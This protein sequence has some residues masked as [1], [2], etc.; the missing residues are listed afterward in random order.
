MNADKDAIPRAIRNRGAVR[1]RNITVP[2]PRHQSGKTL[3]LKQSIDS[4]RDIE[5]QIFLENRAA[6]RSGILAAVAGI[7]N[8]QSKWRWRGRVSHRSRRPRNGKD[9]PPDERREHERK[10]EPRDNV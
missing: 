1:Q 4:L 9:L 10:P 7:E 6:D 8:N 5:S 3:G 2:D